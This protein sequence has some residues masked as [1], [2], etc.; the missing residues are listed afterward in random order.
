MKPK[1]KQPLIAGRFEPTDA[2]KVLISLFESKI[3]FHDVS[4]FSIAERT[5][6]KSP[7][8]IKRSNELKKSLK[9]V[10]RTI[11]LAAKQNMLLDI[12]CDVNI[13]RKPKPKSKNV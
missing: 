13:K 5:G 12:T 4:A 6:K 1:E 7:L 2:K 3:N 10:L 11:D 9:Q 8:H